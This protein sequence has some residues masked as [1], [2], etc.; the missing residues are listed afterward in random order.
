MSTK[1]L[2]ELD[3]VTTGYGDLVIVNEASLILREQE[4][5][6]LL[7]GNGAGKT[8][9]IEAIVGL[10]EIKS[11][12]VQFNG[13]AI[14]G[15][16]AHVIS[17]KGLILVPQGRRLF[18]KMSVE[19]NLLMGSFLPH[20]RNKRDDLMAYVFELFPRLKERRRQIAGSMSGGEQQMLAIG[21]SLMSEP[22]LLIL[23]E[24]S[25]GLAPLLVE[26]VFDAIKKVR[27][28]SKIGILLV[29]Q[30]LVKAL[31][32]ADRGYVLESGD[33]VVE[34]VPE[35]LEDNRFVKKAYFGL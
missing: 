3:K 19:E 8:T 29:E 25:L 28:H 2:L 27:D 20:L 17:S 5:V 4:L 24:P 31:E 14:A 16:P 26:D 12:E 33:I 18:Q 10:N 7:G 6:V 15:L 11:G 34:G 1:S 13:E 21:R 9:L 23:D 30:N 35:E 32:V 22:K